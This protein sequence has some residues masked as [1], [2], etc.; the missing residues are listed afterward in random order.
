M[1]GHKCQHQ[2]QQD[3]CV[4]TALNLY[5]VSGLQCLGKRMMS[6]NSLGGGFR[7]SCVSRV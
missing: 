6:G 4:P 5:T 2:A 1:S 7:V 3:H